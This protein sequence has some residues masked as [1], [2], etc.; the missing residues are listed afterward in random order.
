M[1]AEL[2][3]RIGLGKPKCGSGSSASGGA[4]G[5]R[6]GGADSGS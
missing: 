6:G 3:R 1:V 5:N 2:R 4:G